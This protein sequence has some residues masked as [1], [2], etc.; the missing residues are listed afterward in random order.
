MRDHAHEYM[1]GDPFHLPLWKNYNSNE[2][3]RDLANRVSTLDYVWNL[4]SPNRIVCK[5][6][7]FL[8]LKICFWSEP[9]QMMPYRVGVLNRKL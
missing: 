3:W 2:A 6:V 9:C 4:S 1:V 5:N 7:C 8:F